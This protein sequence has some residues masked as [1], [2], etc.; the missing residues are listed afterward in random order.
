MLTETSCSTRTLLST[1]SRRC[2]S[3]NSAGSSAGA[4]RASAPARSPCACVSVAEL[5]N[6][7]FTVL[8]AKLR[9]RAPAPQPFHHATEAH[10]SASGVLAV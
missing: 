9:C 3:P 1:S 7:P 8:V 4:L 6:C 2:T 5:F 10:A